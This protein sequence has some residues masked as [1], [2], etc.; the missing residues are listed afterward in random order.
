MAQRNFSE[1]LF[2]FGDGSG[3][4]YRVRV[5]L[6]EGKRPAIFMETGSEVVCVAVE[7]WEVVKDCVTRGID[8]VGDHADTE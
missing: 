6:V 4:R 7:D 2:P 1:H 5:E 8:A 3:H